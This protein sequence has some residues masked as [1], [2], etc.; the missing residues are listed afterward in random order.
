MGVSEGLHRFPSGTGEVVVTEHGGRIAELRTEPGGPNLLWRGDTVAPITGGD[1]LWL[2]PERELFYPEDST[3]R[4]DWRCP[5]ELD[6]GSWTAQAQPGGV[7]LRQVALG[8]EMR[9]MVRPLT[10]LPVRCELPWAGYRVADSVHT[11]RGWSGWHLLMAPAPS[12]LYAGGARHPQAM[13]GSPPE[14]EDGSVHAAGTP[15]EWKLGLDPPSDGRVVLAALGPDDPGPL[16]VVLA[17]A[18]PA[19]TYIDV[20][21]PGGDRPAAIELYSSPGY[22]FCEL[23]HHFPLESRAGES[24]VIGAWGSRAARLNLIERLEQGGGE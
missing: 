23:E 13:F 10:E 2:A 24:A 11:D 22:G 4:G 16:L 14:P 12:R 3:E 19:A 7:A 17:E 8:A 9:R 20:W 6:P 21:P 1:R 5:K 15:P 18:D